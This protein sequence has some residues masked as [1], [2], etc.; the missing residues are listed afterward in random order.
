MLQTTP[1]PHSLQLTCHLHLL[2]KTLPSLA[3][4]VKKEKGPSP[5]KKNLHSLP[6]SQPCLALGIL[7]FFCPT[8]TADQPN[9]SHWQQGNKTNTLCH[10]SSNQSPCSLGHFFCL[11]HNGFKHH[12]TNQ[13]NNTKPQRTNI[14]LPLKN[15]K[16]H[17]TW[18]LIP[19]PV[20]N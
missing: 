8:S 14:A 11:E 18:P 9:H 5:Q 12:L 17:F 1:L 19:K 4:T 13:H 20:K 7:E 6:H 3:F 2:L 15:T 16:I 10:G